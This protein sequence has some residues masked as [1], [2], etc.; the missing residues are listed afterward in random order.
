M[1]ALLAA[2]PGGDLSNSRANVLVARRH[3]R[4]T[5]EKGAQIEECPSDQNRQLSAPSDLVDERPRDAGILSGVEFLAGL[6]NVK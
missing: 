1:E 4:Q 5:G 6:E 2:R 3:I